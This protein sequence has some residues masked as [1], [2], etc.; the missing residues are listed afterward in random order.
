[1]HAAQTQAPRA[2]EAL[3]PARVDAHPCRP[4]V[5]AGAR[6]TMGAQAGG[7]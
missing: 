4:P 1:M 7:P 5:L 6:S 3:L 2:D